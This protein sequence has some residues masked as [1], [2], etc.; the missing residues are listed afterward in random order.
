MNT[1]VPD[2]NWANLCLNYFES[3]A[4]QRFLFINFYIIVSMPLLSTVYFINRPEYKPLIIIAHFS[5]IFLTYVFYNLDCR[6]SS[7]IKNSERVI[8]NIEKELFLD[9][10]EKYSLFT[11]E[12]RE[13]INQKKC[14]CGGILNPI[15]YGECFKLL[16]LGILI[17]STSVIC[18]LFTHW[19]FSAN[20]SNNPNNIRY[21]LM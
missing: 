20:Y 14:R 1:N 19:P 6:S 16:F 2:S 7:L 4:R 11:Q 17:Y 9:T 10:I 18:Y 12:E 15:T 8:I 5:E 3:H 21:S 13:T